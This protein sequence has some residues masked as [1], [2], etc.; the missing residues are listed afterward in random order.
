[1][2]VC[3]CVCV[4]ARA[5]ASPQI[6]PTLHFKSDEFI[7]LE[8]RLMRQ[9]QFVIHTAGRRSECII[10]YQKGHLQTP[11]FLERTPL[12]LKNSAVTT[13]QIG[14]VR[15]AGLIRSTTIAVFTETD[16]CRQGIHKVAGIKRRT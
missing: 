12:E 13:N 16:L 7:K 8:G 9:V 11:T 4:C 5:R 3:V 6:D 10:Q 1:M 15:E 2:C 14:D